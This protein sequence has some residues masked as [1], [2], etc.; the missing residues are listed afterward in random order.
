MHTYMYS[1]EGCD[2]VTANCNSTT[3]PLACTSCCGQQIECTYDYQAI[4]SS[5]IA[6]A[7]YIATSYVACQ[8]GYI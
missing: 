4:V 8:C 6:T 7:V 3:F 5:Y 1:D 2:F